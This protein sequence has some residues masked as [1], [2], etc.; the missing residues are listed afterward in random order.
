MV[1]Q[2]HGQNRGRSREV[3]MGRG[4]LMS[5]GSAVSGPIALDTTSA[6]ER[7]GIVPGEAWWYKGTRT[8]GKGAAGRSASAKQYS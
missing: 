6:F 2:G 5:D 4:A 1:A 3:V 7:A 8:V